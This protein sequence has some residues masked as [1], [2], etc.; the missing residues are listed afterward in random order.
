MKRV[1]LALIA[2]LYATVAIADSVLIIDAGYSTVTANVKG[3]L[4]AAGHTATVTT[5][6]SLIPTNKNTYQQVWDLRYSAALTSAEQ[7]SYTSFVTNGGFAYF[8]TENPGCCMA[9]NNSVAALITALGGG[10][11]TIGANYN[12]AA[13]VESNVNTKYMTSG[14]T[15]NYAAVSTIINNQGIPL[16][17][18]SNGEVSGMSWIGRA[19][20]LGSGVTGTIVTV[21]DTNW[22]DNVRFSTAQGATL[23][24]QQNVTALDDIIRGIVAGT[25][26]GTISSNGNGNGVGAN[27]PPP[28]PTV[29]ST[30]AGPNA[31][32]SATTYGT[33]TTSI[34]VVDGRVNG[35]NA[36][37]ITRT[38]TPYTTTPFTNTVTTTPSTVTTYSDGS[39]VTTNGTPVVSSTT[40]NVVTV[41][42]S[43][44]ESATVSAAGLKDAL[45][46]RRFNPFLVDAISTKDGAWATP[47]MGY[48]KTG[49]GSF[50]T[51][52]IGFG[53]QTTVDENTF[54]IA[55]TFGK[56]NSDG[57]QNSKSDAETYGATAYVL[58]RQSDIW[59]KGAVGFNSS[60]YSTVT[61]I[62]TFA[63]TNS[64]KV[65]ANNYYADLTFYTAQEFYGFRPLA[66]VIMNDTK[67]S[68]AY[69]SGSPLLST[70]PEKGSSF[71]ARPY[72]G[73]RYDIDDVFGIE[74][75]VTR[76]KDFGTVGQIRASAKV[77]IVKD[78]YIELTAGADKGSNYTGAVGMIG[79]KIN[80]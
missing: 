35:A 48:A 70:L 22:L 78:A 10:A 26:S 43:T 38:K 63:L 73:I 23:A 66:G 49:D 50:R 41:G 33:A 57:F 62:P 15:V 34:Q 65:K 71:E 27:A 31:I 76:S 51:S 21:A 19:G 79:L 20:A 61:S 68:S 55:G 42:Q 60:E 80:F 59:V 72:A 3:R 14:I 24:Q 67:I 2:V 36:F 4:E 53:A 39:H 16:I 17:S 6:I 7:T 56:S 11:T 12:T 45:A 58:S 25:V 69:E 8:V 13:D 47:L 52:S 37:K 40:G 28:P 9:R 54:G 32:T 75:R 46:V 64:S 30:A 18:D 77:E 5:D 1:L 74:T 29:V 44:S